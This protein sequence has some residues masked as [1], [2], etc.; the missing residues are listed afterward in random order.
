MDGNHAE[1]GGCGSVGKKKISP[2]HISETMT[3]ILKRQLEIEN[4]FAPAPLSHS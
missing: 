3:K 1:V 2:L 4:M